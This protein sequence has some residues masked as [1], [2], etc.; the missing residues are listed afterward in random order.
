MKL[1]LVISSLYPGY[2]VR[3]CGDLSM[4]LDLAL[5]CLYQGHEVRPCEKENDNMKR[6]TVP[7]DLS[8]KL[9]M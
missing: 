8:N 7:Y 3:P 5:S 4:G 9:I 1:D 6:N 2:V